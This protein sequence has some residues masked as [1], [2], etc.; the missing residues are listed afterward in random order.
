MTDLG[1]R[2]TVIEVDTEPRP[3][4]HVYFAC[5][6]HW[7][8]HVEPLSQTLDIRIL[9]YCPHLGVRGGCLYFAGRLSLCDCIAQGDA[10]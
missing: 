8:A 3:T 7:R 5:G 2:G 4:V 10:P 1:I 6:C 9:Q